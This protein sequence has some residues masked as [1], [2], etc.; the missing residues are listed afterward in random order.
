VRFFSRKRVRGVAFCCQFLSSIIQRPKTNINS[1]TS[2]HH[3]PPPKT[4]GRLYRGR[5]RPP[6]LLAAAHRRRGA[7]H[8]R[9]ARGQGAR[10]GAVCECSQ[11]GAPER[12]GARQP[13]SGVK[14]EKVAGS[15]F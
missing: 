14:R 15:A 10:G 11:R 2:I 9:P 7:D 1:K 12:R 13:A 5:P 8:H 6:P 3:T 4:K